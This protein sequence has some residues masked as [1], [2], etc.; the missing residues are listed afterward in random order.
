MKRLSKSDWKRAQAHLEGW[1]ERYLQR[2]TADLAKDLADGPGT[3]TER[4]WAAK[5]AFNVEAKF[6]RDCLDGTTPSNMDLVLLQMIRGGMIDVDDLSAFSDE[7]KQ[8]LRSWLDH[9]D[10]DAS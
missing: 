8:H 2:R 5:E 6:L 3:A 4:F 7:L 1:R 9:L 10:R